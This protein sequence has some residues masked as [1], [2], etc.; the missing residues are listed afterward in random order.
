MLG[1]RW[2]VV[3]SALAWFSSAGAQTLAVVNAQ[4]DARAPTALAAAESFAKDNANN[5]DAWITLARARLQAGKTEQAIT[6]AE[7]GSKLAPGNAQAFF[8]LGNAY[9][10]R[11]ARVGMFSKM[12]L[13]PKLR[14][15]YERAVALDGNLLDARSAL[16]EYFMLVP[17]FAGGSVEKARAQALE[18]GRRDKAQGLLAQGSIAMHEEKTAEA[19]KFFEAALAAQ[20]GDVRV[21]L[22]VAVAY[23]QLERWPDAFRLL[24]NWSAEDPHS[25][26]ARYQFGRAAALSG[27]FLDEG[28]AALLAYLKLPHGSDEPE[29]KNVYFRLGQIHAKAGRKDQARVAFASALKLDPGYSEAKAEMARL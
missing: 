7:R 23:Q 9:G 26:I 13:A 14:D 25:A 16:V 22:A 3:L 1:F 11:I 20:P 12:T 15:A 2:F 21:R 19:M 29:N 18:I 28:A 27:Q 8:W 4:L 5:A 10:F 24:R 17:S 6:A